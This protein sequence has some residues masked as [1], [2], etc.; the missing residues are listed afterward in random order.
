MADVT[1]W[2]VDCHVS[3]VAIGWWSQEARGAASERIPAKLRD[4]ERLH[5][6]HDTTA[7]L[8]VELLRRSEVPPPAAVL[9]ERP[10][11]RFPNPAL[12]QACG[13]I[14][15]AIY[16]AVLHGL[17]AT[18]VFLV[19][20][21]RW[22]KAVLGSARA[23]HE[24]RVRWARGEVPTVADGDE[25]DALAIACAGHVLFGASVIEAV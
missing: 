21:A 11:G 20:V 22:K 6:L 5:A 9:V 1:W 25:A 3:H 17:W 15:A 24:Q 23:D 19:E 16:G 13:V 12:M 4:A 7:R 14:Q 18:P 10:T 2:G 8:T